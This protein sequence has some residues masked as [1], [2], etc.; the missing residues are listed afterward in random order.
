MDQI[1][2][3]VFLQPFDRKDIVSVR[4]K[5]RHH[6]RTDCLAIH[7]DRAR[8]ALSRAASLFD[9]D[10]AELLPEHIYQ[11]LGRR[12][13]SCSKFAVDLKFYFQEHHPND[14]CQSNMHVRYFI[15]INKSILT[16]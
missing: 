5:G 14:H 4:L 7:D 1:Q 6:A 15:S 3:S 9:A 2:F 8:T 13:F 11:P 16:T 10:K 12:Y